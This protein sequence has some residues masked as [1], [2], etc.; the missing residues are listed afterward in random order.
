MTYV[1]VD[2]ASRNKDVLEELTLTR[3]LGQNLYEASLPDAGRARPTGTLRALGGTAGPEVILLRDGATSAQCGD[4]AV[5]VT[6]KKSGTAA[7]EDMAK[8]YG[9]QHPR[10]PRKMSE[11]ANPAMALPGELRVR[12]SYRFN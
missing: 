7:P 2:H 5:S 4:P 8:L 10:L 3:V 1:P 6:L 9:A 12:A 11:C